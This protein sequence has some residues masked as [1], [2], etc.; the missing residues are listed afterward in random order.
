[1]PQV[2]LLRVEAP[3]KPSVGES[4]NGCG[5]CCTSEPCPV[6]MLFSRRASG[7]CAVLEF[8]EEEGRYRCGLVTDS[9]KWLPKILRG[10]APWM[11]KAALRFV[12]AGR[13]CD[14]S[15]EVQR[16]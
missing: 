11:S 5:I 3:A 8:S 16:Q 4:C 1:M 15:V 10:A 2:I 12:A 6:G 13:G 7:P 14:S 9:A